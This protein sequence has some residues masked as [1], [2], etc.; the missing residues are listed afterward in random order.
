MKFPKT[1]MKF[2]DL[3]GM[4]SE[5]GAAWRLDDLRLFDVTQTRSVKKMFYNNN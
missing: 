1:P 2:C 4:F 3:E 5:H